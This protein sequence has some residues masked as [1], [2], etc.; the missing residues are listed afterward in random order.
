MINLEGERTDS[1]LV[2]VKEPSG[3]RKDR[4]SSVS[5]GNYIASE[6]ERKLLK[7]DEYDDDDEL[8]YY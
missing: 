7:V 2:K 4:Y 3:K 6:L 1:G 5:Y 8:V